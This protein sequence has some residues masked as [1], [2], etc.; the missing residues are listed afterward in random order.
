MLVFAVN[1]KDDVIAD[2]VFVDEAPALAAAI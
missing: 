2:I 1:P